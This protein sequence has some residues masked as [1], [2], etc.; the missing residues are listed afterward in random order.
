[1]PYKFTKTFDYGTIAAG[2][3]QDDSFTIEEDGK[4]K[5]IR[6]IKKTGEALI[7]STFWF[8]INGVSFTRPYV[9][10]QSFGPT[11]DKTPALDITVKK[12]DKFDFSLKNNEGAAIG[13]FIE[14]DF[15]E[16]T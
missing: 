15:E 5:R 16:L 4:L 14:L 10:C 6:I 1:M 8:Q 2:A 7:K 3:T 11:V 13:V 9:S 12:G